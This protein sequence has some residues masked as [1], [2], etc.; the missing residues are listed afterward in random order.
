[1]GLAERAIAFVALP[2]CGIAGGDGPLVAEAPVRR[3][4]TGAEKQSSL[5]RSHKGPT[6]HDYWRA[7]RF[8]LA[9][10]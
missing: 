1:M 7:G 3:T 10:A 5:R 4:R 8:R 2:S 6:T 9:R